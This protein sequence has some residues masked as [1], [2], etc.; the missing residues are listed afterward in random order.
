MEQLKLDTIHEIL[1][2]TTKDEIEKHISLAL[3]KLKDHKVNEHLIERFKLKLIDLL[4]MKK[5]DCQDSRKKNLLIFTMA[6]LK[7][8]N[9]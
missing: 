8:I 5:D 9:A 4:E 7:N 3:N 2:S 6:K 1:N